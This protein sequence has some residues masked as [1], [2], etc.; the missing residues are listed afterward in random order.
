MQQEFSFVSLL[1]ITGLAVTVPILAS[2]FKRFNIPIIVGEIIAGIIV[3]KSGFNIIESSV[4][5]EFLTLFGFTYLMFLSGLEVDFTTIATAGSRSAKK[6]NLLKN[7]IALGVTIFIVTLAI[8]FA[9]ALGL[10]QMG[11]ISEPFMIALI[12]STT[13]LGIVVPVL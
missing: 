12:L 5:L 13:S 3:G 8:A 9:V 4:P 6:E 7:P 1:I 2:Q 11:L 10:K